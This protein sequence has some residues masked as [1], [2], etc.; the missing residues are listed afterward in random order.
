MV[1]LTGQKDGLVVAKPEIAAL[2]MGE[3]A[4][5]GGVMDITAG[6]VNAL[7]RP[8]LDPV[9]AGRGGGLELYEELLRDHT[10]A[11]ALQQRQLALIGKALEVAPGG[12]D[13]ASKAAAEHLKGQLDA[14]PWDTVTAGMLYGRIYGYAVGEAMWEIG[15]DGLVKLGSMQVRKARRF[16][17]GTDNALMLRTRTRPQGEVMPDRKFWVYSSSGDS[18]DDPYGFGLGQILYWLVWFKRNDLKLWLQALDKH[19]APTA[20]GEFAPGAPKDERDKLLGALMA[21][22]NSSAITVPQGFAVRLLEAAKSGA[23]DYSQAHE[24]LEHAITRVIIGQTMTSFD[25]SS[26]AQGEV[27]QDVLASIVKADD[28]LLS[29][30]FNAGPARW[31]TAWNFPGAKPPKIRRRVEPPDD[32]KE[33]AEIDT[34]VFALGFEPSEDYIRQR[35]GP[36]WSKKKAPEQLVPPPGLAPR[37]PEPTDEP[38]PAPSFAELLTGDEDSINE[39][40]AALAAS[41]DPLPELLYENVLAFLEAQPDL[42]TARERL[43]GLLP[44][45]PADVIA[46]RIGSASFQARMAGLLGLPLSDAEAEG[47]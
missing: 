47:A 43:A 31:L 44:R 46:K 34:K 12:E 20:I 11:T 26:R 38:P 36:G 14:I 25:G 27:H 28:D 10:V 23:G 5:A 45:L 35:Y 37:T 18:S 9:L 32:L 30:S 7:Y 29:D 17:F 1:R 6:W 33:A 3:A 40:A 16:H 41:D 21:I 2:V 15:E 24:M 22:R 19:A 42:A 8:N 4:A 13:P 39:L